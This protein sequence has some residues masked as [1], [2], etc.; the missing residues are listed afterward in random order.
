MKSAP[1]STP[2]KAFYD[3][4]SAPA[5]AKTCERESPRIAIIVLN[6]NN[7][8]DTLDCLES[9][10]RISYPNCRMII[11]DN[12]SPDGSLD[13]IRAYYEAASGVGM[14]SIVLHHQENHLAEPVCTQ[15][16]ITTE[17]TQ[18]ATDTFD[19]RGTVVIRNDQNYGYAEGNNVGVRCALKRESVVLLNKDTVVIQS[20]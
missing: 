15:N 16:G 6:W 10:R 1:I 7:W 14:I 17:F 5:D 4:S 11:V 8:R 9:L 2:P 13:K 20:S 3:D 19:K 18:I 12:G